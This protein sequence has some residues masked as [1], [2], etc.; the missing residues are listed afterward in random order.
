MLKKCLI[1]ISVIV[2]SWLIMSLFQSKTVKPIPVSKVIETQGML[3]KYVYALDLYFE[4]TGTYPSEEVGII[5]LLKNY[6]NVDGWDGPYI[7]EQGFK[8]NDAWGNRLVYIYPNRCTGQSNYFA[9]YSIGSNEI[10][11]CMKGD[12]IALVLR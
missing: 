2:A 3:K 9:L 1:A 4:D 8:P 11:E 10:D 7:R 12:D 6:E 5:S